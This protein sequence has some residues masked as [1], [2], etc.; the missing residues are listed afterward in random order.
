[1]NFIKGPD[2]PTGAFICGLEGI[3][4]A[5]KTG[6]GKLILKARTEIEKNKIII[7]EIPYMVNKTTLIEEIASL[8]RDKKV[9][10]I[11][12]LRDESDRKGMRVVIFLKKEA[13]YDVV[14]NQLLKH[15][16]LKVTFGVIMLALVRN[17]P[18]ILNLKQMI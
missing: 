14:L 1:M 8:V 18:K 5:Y 16:R 13:N 3:K 11:T 6:R 17:E 4:Q 2:F 9:E 10:G 15:T 7:T 12:D